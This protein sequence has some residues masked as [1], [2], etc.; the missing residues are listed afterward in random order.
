MISHQSSKE[1]VRAWEESQ[2][3]GLE[4]ADLIHSLRE[5]EENT[6]AFTV[7]Q[8]RKYQGSVLGKVD[9]IR[10][11]LNAAASLLEPVK[12]ELACKLQTNH[13]A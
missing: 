11:Q 7:D 4:L 8:T 2:H 10:R 12:A 1:L 5:I 9:D 13:G 3:I 6:A